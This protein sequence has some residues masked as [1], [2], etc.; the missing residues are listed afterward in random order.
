[1]CSDRPLAEGDLVEVVFGPVPGLDR[2]PEG[3][4]GIA[5]AAEP[6][7]SAKWLAEQQDSRWRDH[8]DGQ[9]WSVAPLHGGLLLVPR[10]LLRSFG[11]AG[12]EDGLR[13]VDYANEHSRRTLAALFPEIV[14]TLLRE[15]AG[16][17]AEG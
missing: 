9:W 16:N 6:R 17:G 1:M 5:V 7:P 3:T 14:A 8:A 15:R 13:A 11:R 4:I 2:E 12:R 10:A